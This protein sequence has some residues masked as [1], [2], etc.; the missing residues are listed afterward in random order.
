MIKYRVFWKSILT[1]CEGHGD[2]FKSKDKVLL[3]NCIQHLN[4]K[5]KGEINHWLE[6][7][8]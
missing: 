5:Y 7:K 3:E 6:K 8:I 4:K 1:N 2:W